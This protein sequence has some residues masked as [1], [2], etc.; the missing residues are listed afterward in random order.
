MSCFHFYLNLAV[1]INTLFLLC[2]GFFFVVLEKHGSLLGTICLFFPLFKCCSLKFKHTIEFFFN[3]CSSSVNS[4]G[5]S[6]ELKQKLQDV[7]V[8]RHKL[9]LGKTLGEGIVLLF[10]C[11]CFFLCVRLIF[12]TA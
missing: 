6:D 1:F 9:T 5:I 12:G 11:C 8:D 10:G 4:L 2:V 3:F 7:M